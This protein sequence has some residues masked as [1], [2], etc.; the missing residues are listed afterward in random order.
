MMHQ[1]GNRR[2][3]C[4]ACNEVRD[5][6]RQIADIKGSLTGAS[7]GTL[8]MYRIGCRCD[9]CRAANTE[10]MRDYVARKRA[11]NLAEAS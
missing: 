8:A 10:S 11:E 6:Q 2:C 5:L 7:H 4:Y 1:P 9:V 3:Q